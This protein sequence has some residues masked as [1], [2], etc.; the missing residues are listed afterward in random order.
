M[1]AGLIFFTIFFGLALA[2]MGNAAK[3]LVDVIIIINEATM[4][5][6]MGVLKSVLSCKISQRKDY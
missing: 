6:I 1:R 3:S 4:R 2:T 5:M